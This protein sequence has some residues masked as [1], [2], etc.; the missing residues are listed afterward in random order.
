MSHLCTEFRLSAKKIG[1]LT[2]TKFNLKLFTQK[3]KKKEIY[4]SHLTGKELNV[5]RVHN[6][7][8]WHKNYTE[9]KV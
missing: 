9:T 8:L 7:S 6:M 4:N 5:E 1:V 3:K 2:D